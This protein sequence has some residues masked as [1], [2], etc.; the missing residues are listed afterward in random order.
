VRGLNAA[1]A[2][3]FPGR[4]AASVSVGGAVTAPATYS[5]AQLGALPQATFTV[6]QHEWWRTQT[7]HDTGVPVEELVNDA[8]PTL[9]A[10]R[11]RCCG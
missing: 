5:E 10:A 8:A 4:H 11:T 7:Y 6:T 1:T 3:A 2:A 9:P